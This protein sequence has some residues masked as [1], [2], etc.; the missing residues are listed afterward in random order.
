MRVNLK[1]FRRHRR[2]SITVEMAIVA[3][4]VLLPLFAG[5]ADFLT[6]IAAKSQMNAALQSF[7]AYAWNNPQQATSTTQLGNILG[8]IN[9]HS[10]PLVTFPDG[11]ADGTTTYQPQLTYRCTI[12]PATTYTTQSTPCP[13]TDTQQTLVTYNLA[14]SITLPLPLPM[15][16]TSP[17]ALATSGQ[18][19]IQ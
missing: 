7:Y 16:L 10:L 13:T 15:G 3:S 5:G 1:P 9:Q 18:V 17:Y 8:Q 19:E 6:I 2:A 12:P 11:K 4:M 14:A